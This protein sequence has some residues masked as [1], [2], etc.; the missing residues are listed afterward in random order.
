MYSEVTKQGF[1]SNKYYARVGIHFNKAGNSLL[2]HCIDQ[3]VPIL[4]TQTRHIVAQNVIENRY[5]APCVCTFPES[6]HSFPAIRRNT[7]NTN[8]RRNSDD[9]TLF[10]KQQQYNN[11]ATSHQQRNNHNQQSDSDRDAHYYYDLYPYQQ[12]GSGRDA[13]NYKNQQED[14][15]RPTPY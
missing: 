11:R 10:F 14:S 13:L 1:I 12:S 2:V 5:T 7:L 3:F 8:Q 15:N 6:Q 9:S 4:K